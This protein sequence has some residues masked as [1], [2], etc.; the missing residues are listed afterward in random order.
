MIVRGSTEPEGA[1][2]AFVGALKRAKAHDKLRRLEK[3]ERHGDR[4]WTALA[5]I[6]ERTDPEQFGRRHEDASVPRVAVQIGVQANDVQV[7][8]SDSVVPPK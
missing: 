8:L 4:E 3:I 5:W 7:R 6:N 1:H 2:A